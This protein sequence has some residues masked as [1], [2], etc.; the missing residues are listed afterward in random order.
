MWKKDWHS[1]SREAK[2]TWALTA[3]EHSLH[4]DSDAGKLAGVKHTR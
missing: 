4:R 2:V 3:A 1:R